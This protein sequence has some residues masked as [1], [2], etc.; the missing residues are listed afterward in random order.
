MNEL[1]AHFKR[2][3][4]LCT[5][6][7][8]PFFGIDGNL[9]KPGP[10]PKFSDLHVVALALAAESLGYDSERN[11]FTTIRQCLEASIV[12]FISR[13]CFN[14]R[15]KLLY[16]VMLKLRKN[17]AD[18]LSRDTTHFCIDSMPIAVCRMARSSRC[19]MMDKDKT[20]C[21]DYGYCAS[22]KTYYFGYKL[23]VYVI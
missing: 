16:P 7:C 11:L 19:K 13:R 12:Q 18:F 17:A 10:K 1:Y 21:P 15:R 2:F 3:V 22:Q 9:I 20:L 14:R 4:T 23:P 6:F 5:D 8:A